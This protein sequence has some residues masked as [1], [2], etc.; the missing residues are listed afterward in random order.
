[1]PRLHDETNSRKVL[2]LTRIQY[3]FLLRWADGDFIND[4]NETQPPEPLPDALDRLALESCSGG[5]FFP[6]IEAGRIMKEANRYVEPFRL[7]ADPAVLK[8]G[9]ITEGNALPWQAD[10]Y[11]CQWEQHG[12]IGIGWWP[13]QRPDH[14]LPE[15]APTLPQDW[16]RGISG[17][18]GDNGMVK[19]WHKLGIVARRTTP[20]GKTIFVET[21]RTF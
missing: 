4:L 2:P 20:D 11:A 10:F 18:L 6:G 8:P 9:Q 1:M 17:D 13:A 14:V 3:E 21:E 16:D 19:S 12:T 15:S 7:N 5:A